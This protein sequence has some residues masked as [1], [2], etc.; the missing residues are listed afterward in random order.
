MFGIT[1]VL[2]RW[3]LYILYTEQ[4]QYLVFSSDPFSVSTVSNVIQVAALHLF[5][6]IC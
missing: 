5:L 6:Y 4:L 2:L 1:L 3:T